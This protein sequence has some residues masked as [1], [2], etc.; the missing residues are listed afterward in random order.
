MGSEVFCNLKKLLEKLEIHDKK[1]CISMKNQI[2]TKSLCLFAM[3]DFKWTFCVPEY[4][5]NWH[6][7]GLIPEWIKICLLVSLDVF[8]ITGQYGQANWLGPI[9]MG[10]RICNQRFLTCNSLNFDA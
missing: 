3:W 2:P 7:N 1:R 8:I 6:W 5:Q 10:G 4:G 9:G